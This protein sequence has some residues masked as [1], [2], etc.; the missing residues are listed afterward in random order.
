MWWL[1]NMPDKQISGTLQYDHKD[2]ILLDL[3]GSFRD[4]QSFGS[5]ELSTPEVI[6][7]I[8]DNG[9]LCTLVNIHE[10]NWQFNIPGIPKST[11]KARFLVLGEHFDSFHG[12]KFS[13]FSVNY[14]NLENWLSAKPFSYPFL[15]EKMTSGDSYDI[16]FTLPEEFKVFVKS[17]N[18]EIKSVYELR[19]RGNFITEAKLYSNAYIKFIP[20]ENQT[21]QWF[22][23]IQH[24]FGNLLTILTGECVYPRKIMA[25]RVAQDNDNGPLSILY[26]QDSPVEKNVDHQNMIIPQSKMADS[27]TPVFNQWFENKEKLKSVYD[28]FF[29]TKYSA[30]MFSELHFLS[31]MQVIESFH[32]STK[33]GKYLE[34]AE[35]KEHKDHLIN[36]IPA[37]LES[38]FKASLKS[39]L[40]YGNEYSL[41]KRIQELIDNFNEETVNNLSFDKKFFT[42]RLVDTRNY[43]THYDEEA[44]Q[45]ALKGEN[46]YWANVRLEIFIIALLLDQLGFDQKTISSSLSEHRKF[47]YALSKAIQ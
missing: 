33:G 8:S 14:T 20:H 11:Y 6:L 29:G 4:I 5:N 21:L 47:S 44:K 25:G 30:V 18:T 19:Q 26:S 34:D 39:R 37:G 10:S 45:T 16:S 7:G 13:S 12:I 40:K 42:G 17:L 2:S 38:S 41:R 31:L 23:D 46:L 35:W 43:F 15:P 28:I 9:V 1:P 32:R 3:I 22:L 27:I 24:D 36:Q